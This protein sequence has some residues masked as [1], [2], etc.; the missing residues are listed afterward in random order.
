MF[1]LCKSSNFFKFVTDLPV[2]LV[3]AI[4]KLTLNRPIWFVWVDYWF[5]DAEGNQHRKNKAQKRELNFTFLLWIVQKPLSA[6]YS[7]P[8]DLI[9]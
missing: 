9:A 6:D 5:H 4:G 1:N 8:Y 7:F 3:Q 2:Q